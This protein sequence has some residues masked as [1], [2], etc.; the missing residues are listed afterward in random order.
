MIVLTQKYGQLGN[1]LRLISHLIAA[2]EENQATLY[3]PAF[4]DYA[5]LF[6]ATAKDLWCRYP[7]LPSPVDGQPAM[8]PKWRRRLSDRSVHKSSNWLLQL[9][10]G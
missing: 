3:C 9:G 7:E 8:I 1:R 5:D 10:L 6:P 2:A 4:S